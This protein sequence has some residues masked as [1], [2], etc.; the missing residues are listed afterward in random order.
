MVDHGT[1]KV[2]KMETD[3]ESEEDCCEEQSCGGCRLPAAGPPSAP[4]PQDC[5]E[6]ES[7]GVCH[8]A[9]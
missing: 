3:E 7:C 9:Q 2:R 8:D 4:P 6:D 1:R 5:C